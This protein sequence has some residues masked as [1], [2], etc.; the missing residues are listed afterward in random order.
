M[1]YRVNHRKIPHNLY[2]N[3]V[4]LYRQSAAVRAHPPGSSSPTVKLGAPV[5]GTRSVG[6]TVQL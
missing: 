1:Y 6:V 5:V 4:A 3:T 2:S